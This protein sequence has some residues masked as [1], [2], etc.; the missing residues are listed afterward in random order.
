MSAVLKKMW[1]S[2]VIQCGIFVLDEVSLIHFHQH[3]NLQIWVKI[4]TLIFG[5]LIFI[6]LLP[7]VSF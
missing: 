1:L 2:L 7:D 4:K 6:W 5:L 3:L